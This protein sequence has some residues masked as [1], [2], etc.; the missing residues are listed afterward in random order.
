MAETLRDMVVSLSLNSDNFSA[1]LRSINQQLKEA[2]SQF[3]LASSGVT[4]FENTAAGAQAQLAN[5][6]QTF[7]LQQ[8]AVQQYERALEA[9]KGKLETSVQTHEKL[10]QKLETAK[11]RHADLGQQVDK[12]TADLKEA[13]EAGLK[14]T[15]TYA[16]MEAE[17]EQLK[18]EYAASGQEVQKLE[19]QLSRSESAMQRNADAVTRANTNLNNARAGLQQ[20]QSQI[21]QV[22]SRL[23]RMQNAWLNAADKMAK[24]GEKCTAVGK[25]IEGV[26]KNMSKI[27]AVAVGAGT[28]AV[29]TFASYDDAIRQVYATMGLSESENATQMQALSAAAQE[30]GASTRYSASEA[31]SALNYLALA[32]Y[33]SEQAIAALPTVLGLAQA[34]GIDL[35]SASDMVTDSMSA[36]GLEMSYMPTFADQMAKA[37][38]KSNTSVAQLGE[39]ILKVSATAKNLKGGTVELNTALGVLADNG[40]KGAEGGTHLRNVILSLQNPTDKA[41]AQLKSM[42]VEVYDAQGNM[43]G[44]DEIF[45]DLEKSMA[46][47]T[48]QAKDAAMSEIFNKTDLTAVNALLS[49]CG[50]RWKE[51]SGEISNCDGAAQQ[52][53]DTMEGGIGG[54]F[55]SFKSAVE[56]LAISFGDTLAPTIKSVAE[57]ITEYV[58]KF[59]SLDEAHKK[60]IVKIAAIVA[61]AGPLVLIIGKIITAVGTTATGISKLMVGVTKIPGTVT[62]ITSTISTFA[63]KGV[64]A[65]KTFMTAVSSA[66]GG[67]KG[68]ITV[69]SSSPA[70]IAVFAAAAAYGIYKLIDWASGA[71]A[72]REAQE[73]LNETVKQWGENVTTA[74]EKSKGMSAFGLTV[75]DFK[76]G[77]DSAGSDW[78]TQTIATW[79]DGKKETDQIVTDTVKGFTD[80]TEKIRASLK[81]LKDSAGGTVIGDLDGDLAQLD[82]IDAEVQQILKRKQN[83]YLSEDDKNRLQQLI[84]QREAIQVKYHLV[85]DTEGAFNQIVEGVEAAVSRGADKASTF[86]D[87]YAAATQGLGA[88]TDSLNAEYDARYQVIQAMEDGAAKEQA[89][90]E[91]RQWYDEQGA[92]A[93]QQYYE[94]L[95]QT[96]AETG[97]FAEGGQ[98]AETAAQLENINTLMHAAAGKDSMSSE[99]TALREALAGLDE[100]SIVELEAAIAA[101]ETAAADAG[102]S[103]PEEVLA[104][105]AA[106]EEVKAAATDTSNVFSDDVATSIDT[107]FSG[108]GDEVHEVYASLNCDNLSTAYDAWAAGEHASIIPSLETT[109]LDIS[110]LQDLKGTVTAI[111]G[112]ESVTV[113]I[114]TLDALNG[115]VTVINDK[116]EATTVSLSSLAGLSGTV[117]AVSEGKTVTVDLSTLDA[118]SGTVTV[119]GDNGTATTV[120]ISSLSGLKGTVTAIA[121]GTN[122]TVDLSTLDALKGTVTVINDQGEATTVSISS[123]KNLTGTVTAIGAAKTVTVDLSTL[124]A[125]TGT[126]TIINDAGEAT[127]VS[128]STLNGLTGKVTAISDGQTV[129]VDL[130]TLDTLTGTVTVINDAGEATTVSIA[131]LSG[132]SGTVTGYTEGKTVTFDAAALSELDGTVTSIHVSPDAALPTVELNATAKVSQVNFEEG[133]FTNSGRPD[134]EFEAGASK[135]TKNILGLTDF[136]ASQTYENLHKLALAVRE[137]EAALASGDTNTANAWLDSIY[138]IGDY[139]G[140]DL[141]YNGGVGFQA[142]VQYL[143]NG[144]QLLSEGALNTD[145]ITEFT[146]VYDDLMT[147]MN[148]DVGSSAAY[149]YNFATSLPEG[150]SDALNGYDWNTTADS[151][152]GFLESG[153]SSASDR[154][155]QIGND[156]GAGIGEGEA[157]HD[158][159]ADAGT[160]IDNDETALRNAADSHSPAARFNPLGEDIAAGI[161][162]GM[163]QHDFSGEAE[164]VIAALQSPFPADLFSQTGALVALGLLQGM[165]GADMSGAGSTVSGNVKASLSSAMP[166]SAFNQYGNTAS[167]GV[168]QGMTAYRFTSTGSSVAGSVRSAIAGSLTSSTLVSVGSNAMAGLASGIRSGTASVVSAMRAAA[169][170]AVAAAKAALKIQSPS[171]VFRDEVGTMVMRGFGEGVQSETRNQAKII[172]NAARYLTGAAQGG[173]STGSTDNR[174]TFNNTSNVTLQV[175]EMHVR[176]NQDIRSLA[177]EIAGLTRTQQRGKGLRMA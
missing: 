148:S 170:A 6:Q 116:G 19:G 49:N 47:W 42:G 106:L 130:S 68:L 104:A 93:T 60:T 121:G 155:L 143:A 84:D 14:G 115:T 66:G 169:Q 50:D 73:R 52:M 9:A 62:K 109:T 80:G 105:K 4:G 132:L 78:L 114:S 145:Q 79:T 86:T 100:T 71:K 41:A 136:S 176:D 30:M 27:S 48:Q 75:E 98:F 77:N 24:F 35:A 95:K 64:T 151:V 150:L 102:Q 91:L 2:D 173:I 89:M 29:K 163:S 5:L 175:G 67:F 82:A 103:V 16:E 15:S 134:L 126:V 74:F 1:N 25:K 32:G 90:L 54:A 97:V 39:G 158:F 146:S 43:R 34:G 133:Q 123:L 21:D 160:T 38:Q 88:F 69:I 156:I 171:R 87:A 65:V 70:A 166:A 12:L 18:G 140:S 174:K 40:I 107:M 23:E 118:L 177:I 99:M 63:T 161:G 157:A 8:Q 7:Q 113:D 124:D 153:F 96:A 45:G 162:Q 125:L 57:K 13:E 44:L 36:L 110:A 164:A 127:T 131:S 154:G 76:V 28:V 128:L 53:A 33:D 120:S 81:G 147:V 149:A 139:V 159:S 112:G 129:T 167:S 152:L 111:S 85:A 141:G 101:M 92:A 58:R 3:K 144:M 172:G 56:G 142:M 135:T 168:A 119:I 165:T 17:L 83:G 31:A 108:L 59:T 94:T 122:V 72:A 117:T 138:T 51:L 55:R 20:T 10:S 22:T 26:G 46:G 137:Y 61:A 37:S 11:Q